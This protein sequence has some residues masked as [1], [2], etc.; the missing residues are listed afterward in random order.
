MNTAQ[1]LLSKVS[2]FYLLKDAADATSE[3]KDKCFDSDT[4]RFSDGSSL[5][6]N[7]TDLQCRAYVNDENLGQVLTLQKTLA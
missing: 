2:S 5:V 4:Y 6:M 1:Q 7:D 3:E